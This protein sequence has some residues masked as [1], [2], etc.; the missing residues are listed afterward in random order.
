[1]ADAATGDGT[2]RFRERQAP[3]ATVGTPSG[4]LAEME[5]PSV[6]P[7]PGSCE[8]MP[9]TFSVAAVGSNP[10]RHTRPFAGRHTGAGKS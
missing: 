4:R 7:E 6:L 1:M 8:P 2:L 9:D 3:G 10:P 5:K